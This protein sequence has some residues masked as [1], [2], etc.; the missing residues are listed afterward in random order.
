MRYSFGDSTVTTSIPLPPRDLDIS[1]HVLNTGS[2][3]TSN[4]AQ[5]TGTSMP[6]Y[7]SNNVTHASSSSTLTHS[8][9]GLGMNEDHQVLIDATNERY[10]WKYATHTPAP[11][12][13]GEFLSMNID[14]TVHQYGVW[15]HEKSL[16]ARVLME[17]KVEP[18][19]TAALRAFINKIWDVPR[20]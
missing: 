2:C 13:K 4:V 20:D 19:F 10:I 18:M 5:Y 14:V 15:E 11:I 1:F 6:I 7:G 8:M 12:H 17:S 9:Q 3:V 16:I